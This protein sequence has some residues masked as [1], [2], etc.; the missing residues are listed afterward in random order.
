MTEVKI[1]TISGEFY[2][3]KIR[4]PFEDYVNDA[5]SCNGYIYAENLIKQVSCVKANA[6]ESITL[7]EES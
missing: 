6:I 5:M 7:I 2:F 4:R 3:A 1:K